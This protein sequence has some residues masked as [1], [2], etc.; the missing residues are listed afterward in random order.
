[1]L[2]A[3]VRRHGDFAG[4]ED[5][6]QE[7]L[8]AAATTWPAEG[9]PGQPL[10]WLIRVTYRRMADQYRSDGARRHPAHAAGVG[11][12]T[13]RE[14]AAAFLV[15]EATMA[16]RISPGKAKVKRRTSRSLCLRP[17][18][19]PTACDRCCTCST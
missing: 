7:A 18:S 3:V 13:T 15:P 17:I 1:M 9:E 14:I 8:L 19:R 16:Q 6:V 2:G 5:T 10:A 4:A 11:G 12:L